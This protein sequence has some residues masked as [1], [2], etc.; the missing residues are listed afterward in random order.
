M[1][2]S[3]LL[4]HEPVA[5]GGFL[6][7]ALLSIEG[8]PRSDEDRTP[9]NLSLVLDRSGSMWGEPLIAAREAAIRII[10]R[11]APE[12]TVSV[13][14]YDDVVEVVA[15]PAT[16]AEQNDLTQRIRDIGPGGSTNLSGGW[17]RG[18]D[19]VAENQREGAVN[20][21]ILLTDGQANVGMTE[22][23]QLVGL[24]RSGAG[25]GISTTTVGFG[26]HFDED[27]LKSMADA[28]QGGTYYIEEADQAAGIFA[29]EL[30]GLMSLA[31]QNVRVAIGPGAD[32]GFVQVHHQYP[33]HSEG[34]VLTLEVGDLYAREPRRIVMEFL[35]PPKAK[36]GI[37]YQV[38]MVTVT[39]HVLMDDG[40]VELQ[41]VKLPIMLSP[42]EGGIVQPEVR[43]EV[44]LVAAARAREEAMEAR[45][46]GDW[47]GASQSL[48]DVV[49]YARSTGLEDPAVMEE[50]GDLEASAELFDQQTVSEADEKYMKQRVYS[51]D[52]SRRESIQR[53]RRGE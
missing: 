5:D 39:A 40:G 27:L 38:A 8:N 10:Q 3:V 33:N 28:G 36:A 2:T 43:R 7:R 12:D 46:R 52:R 18:R 50:I 14:A 9:L 41:T 45:E 49:A 22:P 35:L 1:K 48:R 17:L 47:T 15:P 23:G 20:R 30:D 19:L 25:T 32:A 11:L 51:S 6:V 21:V 34:D 13:V 53:Y 24:C 31:A 29:E 42:V 4:D 26:A 37:D 44:L 16:G